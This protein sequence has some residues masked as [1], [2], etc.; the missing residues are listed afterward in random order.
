M[1]AFDSAP[2]APID[3]A[4]GE[5]WP[6]SACRHALFKAL[7]DGLKPPLHE[8][9]RHRRKTLFWP[10]F[11]V[12]RAACGVR[13]SAFGVRRSAFGVRQILGV[14]D[15]PVIAGGLQHRLRV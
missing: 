3:Q 6:T 9:W 7:P 15:K 1:G 11:G 14:G 13:R 4:P 12:R 2:T 8:H 10:V 5:G